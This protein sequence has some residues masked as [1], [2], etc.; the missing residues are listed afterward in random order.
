MWKNIPMSTNESVIIKSK[1][2]MNHESFFWQLK[3]LVEW[4][5]LVNHMKESPEPCRLMTHFCSLV[6]PLV[7]FGK[8]KKSLILTGSHSLT[9]TSWTLSW[10]TGVLQT[11]WSVSHIF[12]DQQLHEQRDDWWS[13]CLHLFTRFH[14]VIHTRICLSRCKK[15]DCANASAREAEI[16]NGRNKETAE[17]GS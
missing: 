6:F 16:F 7:I 2:K 11:Y 10:N 4:I 1:N 9:S 15:S 12:M 5:T 17:T 3:N 14:A 8:D 13:Q